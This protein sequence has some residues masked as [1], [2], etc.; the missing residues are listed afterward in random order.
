MMARE[1]LEHGATASSRSPTQD[2]SLSNIDPGKLASK[3]QR[4][5]GDDSF[6]VYVKHDAYCIQAPRALSHA[7]I[8]ECEV[9]DGSNY[10]L[11]QKELAN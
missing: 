3:L 11:S 9:F 2:V 5:F 4:L 8:A 6:E 1:T 7:E 10:R